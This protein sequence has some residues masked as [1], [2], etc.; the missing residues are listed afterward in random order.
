MTHIR[1]ACVAIEK[2]EGALKALPAEAASAGDY[3]AV[4]LLA[5]WAKQLSMLRASAAEAAPE[6][7]PAHKPTTNSRQR[8]TRSRRRPA[9]GDYP[10]FSRTGETI[11]KTSW[12]KKRKQEYQHRGPRDV[13]RLVLSALD[14]AGARNRSVTTDEI[15]PLVT[16]GDTEV[17]SYQAYLALACLKGAGAVESRGREG[18]QLSIGTRALS[19]AADAI[20]AEL[21]ESE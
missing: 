7:A 3:D 11:V 16:A 17:P 4:Q 19:E 20:W 10:R 5:E 21:P 9:R 6:E 12:S 1:K 8:R 15:F 2:A 14:S 13:L 18:Y